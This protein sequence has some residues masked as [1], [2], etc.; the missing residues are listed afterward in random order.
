MNPFTVAL[1]LAALVAVGAYLWLRPPAG[2]FTGRRARL[3]RDLELATL[4]EGRV[5]LDAR[6]PLDYL[7]QH[8]LQLGFRRADGPVRVPA[9]ERTGHRL[10]LVPFEHADEG[11]YFYMGIES[12]WAPRSELMLHVVTPLGGNRRVETSTLPA[13]ERLPAPPGV[14]L[15]VAL[16]V[17][18]VEE[19]WSHHRRAL[20]A[21]ER[22]ERTGLADGAWRSCALETYRAWLQAAVRAQKLI[23]EPE[24]DVYRVR[25]RPRGV[26]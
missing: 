19:L 12:G 13:L 15:R 20:T 21:Y 4:P 24:R 26:L 5:P 11:T 25:P 3:P 9:F 18:S 6:A 7:D 23:L 17:D 22:Q 1:I 2:L 14:D 16:E 8:L 10:L